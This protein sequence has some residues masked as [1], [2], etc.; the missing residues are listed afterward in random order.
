MNINK[1]SAKGQVTIPAKLRMALGASP[2]DLIAYELEGK[3]L[4]LKKF[5]PF[6]AAYQAAIAGT[7]EEWN[8]PED[9]EAFLD[10]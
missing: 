10:L 5:E 9:H 6:A 3:S 8:S 2:G 1:I 7:I 4:R